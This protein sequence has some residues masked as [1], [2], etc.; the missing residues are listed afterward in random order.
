MYLAHVSVWF[1]LFL[2]GVPTERIDQLRLEYPK[3]VPAVP[4]L[5]TSMIISIPTFIIHY[6]ITS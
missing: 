6:F 2:V 5:I 4:V 1:I 3:V